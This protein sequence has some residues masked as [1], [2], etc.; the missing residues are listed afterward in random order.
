MTKADQPEAPGISQP[1]AR[2]DVV[3]VHSARDDGQGY[4]VLRKREQTLEIGE[5]RA[6]EEGR[7][8]H[9]DVVRLRPR[10]EHERLFDVEVVMEAPKARAVGSGPPQVATD[11]YRSNWEAI[12]GR[13]DDDAPN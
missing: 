5:L 2:E 3:F 11:A 8:L 6:M 9:G 12:F 1:E 7:P 13:E 10:Q 4:R